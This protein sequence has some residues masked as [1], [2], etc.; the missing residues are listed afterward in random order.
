MSERTYVFVTTDKDAEELAQK[1]EISVPAELGPASGHKNG[2]AVVAFGGKGHHS[3]IKNML[4]E[5]GYDV[6]TSWN[7]AVVD[8]YE[9]TGDSHRLNGYELEDEFG[10]FEDAEEI[11]AE[12]LSSPGVDSLREYC[13]D[14][15]GVSIHFTWVAHP[16]N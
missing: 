8:E 11:G 7:R 16:D 1:M 9:D 12:V 3:V 13:E 15:F 4:T 14:E 5:A 2:V 6:D 10:G